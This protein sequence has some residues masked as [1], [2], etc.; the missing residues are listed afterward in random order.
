MNHGHDIIVTG[1]SCGSIE[2][3]SSLITNLPADLPA[4]LFV[5]IHTHPEGPSFITR[6]L[7]RISSLKARTAND[8]DDIRHGT[9]YILPPDHHLLVKE[10]LVRVIRGPREKRF[11][12]AIDPLFRT[13]AVAYGS[14]VIGVLLSGYLDD[15]VSGLLAHVYEERAKQLR[16]HA[17][18]IR[19]HLIEKQVGFDAFS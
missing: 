16:Q 8:P 12:P 2:A 9:I 15:G 4:A 19:R 6:I 13:A 10:N 3:L 11:R 18:V 17:D 7:N 1:G 14:R 5:V